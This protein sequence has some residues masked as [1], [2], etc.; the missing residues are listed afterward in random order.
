[1]DTKT[2]L[3]WLLR[4]EVSGTARK[5]NGELGHLGLQTKKNALNWGLLGGAV[6]AAGGVL[7]DGIKSAID[8]EVVIRRLNTSLRANAIGWDGNTQAIDDSIVKAEQWSG[9]A[10]DDLRNSLSLLVGATHDVTKAQQIQTTAMDLARYKGISLQDA[11]EALTKVETGSYRILKS[12]GIELPKG[13]T[14]VQALAAVEKLAAGQ[15]RE[16]GDS[17]AAALDKIGN[18]A[19]DAAENLGE[20]ALQAGDGAGKALS[21]L[22]DGLTR[23]TGLFYEGALGVRVFNKDLLKT[24]NIADQVTGN[25]LSLDDSLT[26]WLDLRGQLPGQKQPKKP[27]GTGTGQTAFAS[28]GELP[29]SGTVT[30]GERGPERMTLYPGGGGHVTPNGGGGTSHGHDI[31][32]DGQKVGELLDRRSYYALRRAA[33]TLNRV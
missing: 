7:L 1:V 27:G 32:L 14:Q 9:F 28:G 2:T 12:L 30:V 23:S 4:D 10:K 33:P 19:H 25:M 16:Y 13:A 22:K 8:S 6:A 21:F 31:Y 3:T 5:I 20:F 24:A 17:H 26:A 29:M 15:A 18:A 11:T